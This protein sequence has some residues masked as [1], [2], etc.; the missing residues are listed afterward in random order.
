[1]NCISNL[2]ILITG[3]MGLVGWLVGGLCSTLLC[4]GVHVRCTSIFVACLFQIFIFFLFFY[5]YCSI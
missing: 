5:F 4:S 3:G 2:Y 1:M